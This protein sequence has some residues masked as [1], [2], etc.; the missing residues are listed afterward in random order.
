MHQHSPLSP[1]AGSTVPAR[2]AGR[3]RALRVRHIVLI[4]L[5]IWV[6]SG[7]YV[8]PTEEQAVLTT[9]GAVANDQVPPGVGWHFPWPV[10]T[11]RKLKVQELKR[12]FIGGEVADEANAIPADPVLSQFLTGDQNI[13]NVRAVVQYSV[14]RPARYL[15][16]ASDV[17]RAVANAVEAAL[18]RQVSSR[19]VD[20]VLTTEQIAIQKEVRLVAQTLVDR[21]D[22]GVVLSTVNIRSVSPPAEAADA[23][24][25]VASARADAARIVN[26]AEGYRNDILPRA[27]G[28]AQQLLSASRGYRESKIQQAQGDAARFERLAAEYRRSPEVTRSRLY[29]E[30]MEEILPR[31]RKTIVDENGN[32][33]LTIIRRSPTARTSLP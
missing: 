31:L 20:E 17:D 12:A 4:A 19:A 5:T 7:L 8:V 32:L 23:F 21:F 33:D 18:E 13:I 9:F 11:V 26:E 30:T 29:L 22:L 16:R 3:L 25:D 6:V 10:G 2:I 1:T 15:F 24:R 14:T 28:E 27:R